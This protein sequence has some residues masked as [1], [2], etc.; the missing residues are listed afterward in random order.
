MDTILSRTQFLVVI[1][2]VVKLVVILVRS[3][4]DCPLLNIHVGGCRKSLKFLVPSI[5]YAANN[6]IYLY[7]ITL[8]SPPIW[9][10]LVSCRTVLTA[11]VYKF[12]LRR[13]ISGLQFL[14]CS[15]IVASLVIAKGP[16]LLPA[17]PFKEMLNSTLSLTDNKDGVSAPVVNAVPFTAIVLGFICAANSVGAAV[18]MENLFQGIQSGRDIFG[19]TILALLLRSIGWTCHP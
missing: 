11:C 6:N 4:G 1:V 8:V 16:D 18:Y 13:Q 15:L 14:G 7:A 19:A 5:L 9:G 10:I 17:L 12:I 3:N 2:E